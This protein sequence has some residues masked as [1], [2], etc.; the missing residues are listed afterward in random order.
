MVELALVP[1]LEVHPLRGRLHLRR[2]PEEDFPQGDKP[3]PYTS[4]GHERQVAGG[5]TIDACPDRKPGAGLTV[6]PLWDRICAFIHYS[7]MYFI[8][9]SPPDGFPGEGH[10][11]RSV[12]KWEV[13]GWGTHPT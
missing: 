8:I 11:P 9:R 4:A 1:R 10:V 7:H 2:I 13:S 6:S 3:R 5:R 12:A